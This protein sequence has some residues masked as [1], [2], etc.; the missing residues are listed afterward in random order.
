[1][2][3]VVILYILV[4]VVAI[5]T[6][7]I[8]VWVKALGESVSL[9]LLVIFLTFIPV[10]IFAS[11]VVG[12]EDMLYVLAFWTVIYFV[13]HEINHR[14]KMRRIRNRRPEVASP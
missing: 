4:A 8:L 1:M 5:I 14:I 9:L 6:P 11:C 10:I 3:K 13:T 2:D 12:L 7:T